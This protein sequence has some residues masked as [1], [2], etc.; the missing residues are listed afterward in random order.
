VR[1]QVPP[2]LAGL[3]LREWEGLLVHDADTHVA[4]LLGLAFVDE[5]PPG[6]GVHFPRTRSVHTFG[7]RFA[8]DL[9]WLDAD[10]ALVRR[11]D[12]VPPRRV[13]TCRAARSVVEVAARP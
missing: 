3:P 5:L 2:R 11:D 1:P 9:L 10:G 4:R 6:V 8:L 13:R 12:A 7:M